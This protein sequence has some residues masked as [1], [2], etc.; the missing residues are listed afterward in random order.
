MSVDEI[1]ALKLPAA[2]AAHIYLWTTHRFLHDA[3]HVLEAWGCRHE[4]TLT[5]VKNNG[6][7]PFSW[8]R[9]T[10]FVLFGR[11]GGALALLRL[12]LPVHFDGKV[13]Q[14]SRKPDE[15]YDLVKRASPGPR[16]DMFAREKREGFDVWGNET[17]KFGGAR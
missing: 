13:R 16:I 9:T 15:F 8:M 4:V 2:D 6:F 7:A 17:G 11:R 3:Y 1:E 10:E 5:W 14:H 12:G